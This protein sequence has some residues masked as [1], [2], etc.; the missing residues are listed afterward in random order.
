MGLPL[1]GWSPGQLTFSTSDLKSYVI[2]GKDFPVSDAAFDQ[3]ITKDAFKRL[4][5]HE[6]IDQDIYTRTKATCVGIG[7]TCLALYDNHLYRI[8]EVFFSSFFFLFSSFFLSFFSLF[9]LSLFFLCLPNILKIGQAGQAAKSWTQS[10]LEI[11][12]V[13]DD[14]IT[15]RSQLMVLCDVKYKTPADEDAVYAAAKS[16]ADTSLQMLQMTA[17]EAKEQAVQI[18]AALL[19]VPTYLTLT[20]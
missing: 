1:P 18:V 10:T 19:K 12:N 20:T 16:G 8:R 3:L 6:G 17:E 5:A 9:F 14:K 2:T 13:A 11:L 4:L 7:S 15:L